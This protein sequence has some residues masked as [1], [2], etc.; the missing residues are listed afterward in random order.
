MIAR[1]LKKSNAK[2]RAMWRL[3]CKNRPN[4]ARWEN[5]TDSKKMKLIVNTPG[6]QMGDDKLEAEYNKFQKVLQKILPYEH[7]KKRIKKSIQ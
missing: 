7:F 6:E 3:G 1:G 2:D 4:P 5:K